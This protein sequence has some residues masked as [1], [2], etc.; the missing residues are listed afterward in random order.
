M[1]GQGSGG[2]AG[3]RVFGVGLPLAQQLEQKSQWQQQQQPKTNDN[4]NHSLARHGTRSTYVSI[5]Y[6]IQ[7]TVAKRYSVAEWHRQRDI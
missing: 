4:S 3:E 5:R 2:E 1:A 7:D 6:K